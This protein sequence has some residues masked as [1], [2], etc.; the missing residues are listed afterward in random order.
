MMF[1]DCLKL[2]MRKDKMNVFV[3]FEISSLNQLCKGFASQVHS[4]PTEQLFQGEEN[5]F[6]HFI[7]VDVSILLQW[8]LL[9][10]K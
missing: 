2:L 8:Q 6:S 5:N 7:L 1:L 9:I 4:T 3:C 10:A